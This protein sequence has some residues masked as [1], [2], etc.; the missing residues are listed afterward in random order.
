MTVADLIDVLK[1]Q[2]PSA[3][4]ILAS[5]SEGN[6]FSPWADWSRGVYAAETEH[7]GEFIDDSE[8]ASDGV[9]CVTLWPIR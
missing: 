6:S 5:D 3:I 9:L 7:S 8:P 2:D 4:I 1:R